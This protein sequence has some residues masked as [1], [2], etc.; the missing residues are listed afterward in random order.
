MEP[1][2]KGTREF[3]QSHNGSGQST[4][5]VACPILGPNV[6]RV[7]L[8]DNTAVQTHVGNPARSGSVTH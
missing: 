4:H 2:P 6:L 1:T 8:R 7:M 3:L 5:K